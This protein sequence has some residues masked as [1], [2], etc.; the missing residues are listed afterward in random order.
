[1]GRE[2]SQGI[3]CLHGL[4]VLHTR[5]VTPAAPSIT[6]VW[7]P[8]SP[9]RAPGASPKV[10]PRREFISNS[11]AFSFPFCHEAWASAPRA[12]RQD[13]PREF[14]GV[15]WRPRSSL[16]G[17]ATSRINGTGCAL[18]K[19]IKKLVCKIRT[20]KKKSVVFTKW[21]WVFGCQV[22]DGVGS[23]GWSP[24]LCTQRLWFDPPLG[25]CGRRLTA[26]SLSLSRPLSLKPPKSYPRVRI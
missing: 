15:A 24:V 13:S 10:S 5:V 7:A 25:S 3:L 11:R 23:G 26:V 17:S 21:G 6:D 19:I 12:G 8:Q 2:P 4:R 14:H 20:G 1:M 9:L 16:N 18:T 22:K